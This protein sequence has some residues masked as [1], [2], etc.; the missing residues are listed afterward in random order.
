[1]IRP[2]ESMIRLD[3]D[4]AE[5]IDRQYLPATATAVRRGAAAT[6]SSITLAT[7]RFKRL[8]IHP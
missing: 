3:R 4:V 5:V 8:S 1:M 7:R 6:S 2:L